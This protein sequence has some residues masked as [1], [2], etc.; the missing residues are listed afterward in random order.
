MKKFTALMLVVLMLVALVPFGASAAETATEVATAEQF[1][2]MTDGNYVLTAN[3]TLPAGWTAIDFAGTLDGNGKT[4]TVPADAPIFEKVSG[5]IKNL[6]LT[7]KVS[8]DD[9]DRSELGVAD[10][11]T[12]YHPL[13]VLANYT[14][15][16][17]IENVHST[18]ELTYASGRTAKP[19][20][21]TTVGGLI[22]TAMAAYT[23]E[24]EEGAKAVVLGKSC[25]IKNVTVAGKITADWGASMNGNR[26]NFGGLL[27]AV[28]GNTD[29]SMVLVSAQMNIANTAGNKG[30]IVGYAKAAYEAK[31]TGADAM[32]EKADIAPTFTDCLFNGSFALTGNTGERWGGIVG[33][34][35][36]IVIKNCANEG[37]AEGGTVLG[38]VGYG[39]RKKASDGDYKFYVENSVALGEKGC[40]TWVGIKCVADVY[41]ELKN[42]PV[43][44]GKTLNGSAKDAPGM[45]LTNI[46]E[47]ADA[48]AVRAAFLANGATNFTLDNNGKLTLKMFTVDSVEEF[49]ALVNAEN[50]G[51][52]GFMNIPTVYVTT[53][54]DMK[55]V[56]DFKP[57][58]RL[59]S[60]NLDFQGH[61]ISNL[62]VTSETTAGGNFGMIAI[63]VVHRTISNLKIDNCLLIANGYERVALVVGVFD[64]GDL[65]NATIEN[66]TVKATHKA[67]ATNKTVSAA[68]GGQDYGAHTIDITVRNVRLESD[69][70]IAFTSVLAT[71][72]G[73]DAAYTINSAIIENVTSVSNG[74]SAPVEKLLALSKAD[75]SYLKDIVV[76]EGAVTMTN[77]A[78][79]TG[80]VDPTPVVP[81]PPVEPDT[82]VD[83]APTGD[84]TIAL[85]TVALVSLA[86]VTVIAKKKITE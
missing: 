47:C 80:Y 41:S 7:G 75:V 61:T 81:D 24:G 38:I 3:I 10:G 58:N 20:E 54:L 66:S 72:Y 60:F 35:R 33:Y 46:T 13:G 55:D 50:A 77:T 82:P 40:D 65:K 21:W 5:T 15:G 70:A 62:V 16:A 53:D 84:M 27:G 56:K 52:A 67:D 26:D 74:Q 64:R 31:M 11:G 2:A 1:A 25:T 8:L 17:T 76:P 22:G 68:I 28:L 43:L 29:V 45:T 44:A 18:V 6:N 37:N 57:F 14:F 83:P 36:N 79:A 49:V 30:G 23:V 19:S 39:N 69:T 63:S 48:A 51:T 4:V 78:D 42:I 85:V 9:A 73:G 59:N 12:L 86:A 71:L 34:A 32:L